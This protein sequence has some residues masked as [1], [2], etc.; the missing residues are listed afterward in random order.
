MKVKE[1]IA[2]LSQY[3]EEKEVV[4]MR[5]HEDDDITYAEDVHE[6]QQKTLN[7]NDFEDS[8]FVAIV[9]LHKIN[10]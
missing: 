10:H 8:E 4:V 9:L 1:L 5:E 6:V 2:E 7:R 3:D